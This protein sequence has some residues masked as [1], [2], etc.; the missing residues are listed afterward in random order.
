MTI[1]Q[2]FLDFAALE[3]WR[4]SQIVLEESEVFADARYQLDRR[5]G[6]HALDPSVLAFLPSLEAKRLVSALHR[7]VEKRVR[8]FD[9][10]LNNLICRRFR[11]CERREHPMIENAEIAAAIADVFGTNGAAALT[12][13]LIKRKFLDKLCKCKAATP[14]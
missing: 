8:D 12:V 14:R 3:T 1:K 2:Q 10:Q 6:P 7:S 4:L 13:L 11:W 5:F 9:D